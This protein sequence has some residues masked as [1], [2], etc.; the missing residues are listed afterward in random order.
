M[1]LFTK[2]VAVF[3]NI[4]DWPALGG[5]KGTIQPQFLYFKDNSLETL[6]NWKCAKFLRRSKLNYLKKKKDHD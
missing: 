4:T 1:N 6:F 2:R 3:V 5:G